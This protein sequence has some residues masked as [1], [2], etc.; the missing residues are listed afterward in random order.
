MKRYGRRRDRPFFLRNNVNAYIFLPIYVSVYILISISTI[1]CQPAQISEP[2]QRESHLRQI[3]SQ[4][5]NNRDYIQ[6]RLT[7]DAPTLVEIEITNFCNLR[8]S[9]CRRGNPDYVREPIVNMSI[10]DFRN[11][12]DAYDLPMDRIQF[13]GSSEPTINPHLVDMIRYVV[14]KKRPQEVEL[15]T[16]G[17]LLTPKLCKEIIEA[18][19]TVIRFSVDGPN[20]EAYQA[21]RHHKLEPVAKNMKLLSEMVRSMH[22]ENEISIWI[23]CVITNENVESM[24]DMPEFASKV[25]V[26]TL[27]FRIFETNLEK[28]RA[29]AVY[30]KERLRLLR[31]IIE[32]RAE[33]LNIRCNLW[34][35]DDRSIE[36][37][38]LLTEAH[39]NYLGHLTA[40]YHLPLLSIGDKLGSR[41]F[42]HLWN[43]KDVTLFIAATERGDYHHECNCL[44][45]IMSGQNEDN[46]YFAEPIMPIK[47]DSVIQKPT[48][49]EL[50]TAI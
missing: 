32:E 26:D 7:R 18:G 2:K 11:I 45:A 14:E 28:V 6:Q 15:I 42:S 43:S 41:P 27:E 20:E 5:C 50:S 22:K 25:G 24:V 13:C 21:I 46:Q 3:V 16:N 40:C 1:S 47:I 23:S 38:N 29:S 35:I 12:I 8:C 44:T 48:H 34:D 19:I 33:A 17:T 49:N 4:D 39:I 31:P 36:P 30:D 9:V 10:D 37:C